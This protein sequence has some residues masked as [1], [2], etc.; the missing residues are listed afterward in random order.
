M[1]P[2]RVQALDFH[3]HFL[4][5]FCFLN[6]SSFP[7]MFYV[8]DK[9][10]YVRY[11]SNFIINKNKRSCKLYRDW[12]PFVLTLDYMPRTTCW[13]G[14]L[15]LYFRVKNFHANCELFSLV[16]QYL[17]MIQCIHSC[18]LMPLLSLP[19]SAT[20]EKQL[21]SNTQKKGNNFFLI[22]WIPHW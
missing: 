6:S 8:A 16:A 18:I 4:L 20:K 11:C 10:V 15:E 2:I 19:N 21:L 3:S 13:H 17:T 9:T 1:W 12:R 14:Q 22:S 5:F 7:Q